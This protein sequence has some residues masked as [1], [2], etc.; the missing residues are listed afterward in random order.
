MK[1]LCFVL[2]GVL[3]GIFLRRRPAVHISVTPVNERGEPLTMSYPLQEGKR[4]KLTANPTDAHGHPA[5][6]DG[7]ASWSSSDTST[8][9]VAPIAED[10]KGLSAWATG[11]VPGEA[12]VTCSAMENGQ[13]LEGTLEIEVTE[14]DA[15]Q[16]PIVPGT[17]ED[18]P[19]P[20][21]GLP[22]AQPVVDPRTGQRRA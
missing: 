19:H 11:V 10:Q 6:L 20:D 12:T 4:V 16:I 7:K 21:Q 8:V 5:N 15:T 3:L 22:P 17:P 13:T 2:L 9:N 18:A 14:A 1:Q